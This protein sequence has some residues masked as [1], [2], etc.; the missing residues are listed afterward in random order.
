ME[1]RNIY[2]GKLLH[3]HYVSMVNENIDLLINPQHILIAH[4]WRVETVE[5]WCDNDL[6]GFLVWAV[7]LES[8]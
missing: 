1:N 2:A 6:P 7:M 5:E 4:T 3:S 8:S